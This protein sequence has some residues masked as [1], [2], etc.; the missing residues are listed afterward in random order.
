MCTPC[1]HLWITNMNT[2][3]E[4]HGESNKS[5]KINEQLNVTRKTDR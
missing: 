5:T 4:K 3:I 2:S 1:S